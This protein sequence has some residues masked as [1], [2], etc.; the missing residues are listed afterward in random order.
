M[1][2]RD[3]VTCAELACVLEVSS[4]KPGNVGRAYDFKDTKYEDF[5]AGGIA[6]GR[7]IGESV[8]RG[9]LAAGRKIDFQDVGIGGLIKAAV[10]ESRRWHSGGNTNLGI[11]MLLVPLSAACG[12]LIAVT[13]AG[14]AEREVERGMENERIREY[15]DLIIKN[16]THED[17]VKLYEAIN[18]VK[19]G[20]MGRV[21]D[22]D[23]YDE[24]SID[25]I[26]EKGLNLHDVMKITKRDSIAMELV[27]GM[28]KSFEIGYPAIAEEFDRTGD[29]NKAVVYGFMAILAKCPDSHVERKNGPDVAEEISREAARIFERGMNGGMDEKELERFDKRLRDKDNR[30]NPGS[31]ADLVTSSLM[32]ALLNG[33]KV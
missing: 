23:V 26:K 24:R 27:T 30:F 22:V 32:I 14:R 9:G 7:A 28:R 6:I 8:K 15:L 11:A 31:T 33:L 12:A 1:D 25:V 16:S 13:G 29:V 20:G 17:T 21:D 19:P 10:T 2:V 18:F 4:Q 3:V 5:L